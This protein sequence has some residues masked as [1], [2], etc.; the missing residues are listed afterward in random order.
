VFSAWAGSDRDYR[1]NEGTSM[2]APHLAG[3]CAL[4][5]TR[6]PA[7]S[8]QQIIQRLLSTVDVLPSL[9]GL[10]RAGGRLNLAAALAGSAPPPPPAVLP[11]PSNLTATAISANEVRLNWTDHATTETGYEIERSTDNVQFIGSGST[12][13]DATT[14]HV[15]GL[16]ASTSYYFRVRAMQGSTASGYSNSATATTPA[17]PPPPPSSGWTGA[18]VGAVA[19]A[20][21]GTGSG[22]SFTVSGSGADIWDR[23]DEFHY[24]FQA[25]TGD[26][27][28]IAQVTGM[29]NTDGWAKAGI[30]LRE[31]TGASDRHV[32][33]AVNPSGLPALFWRS[34]SG[35]LTDFRSLHYAVPRV[36]LKLTRTANSFQAW[37]SPDGVNWAALGAP[38]TLDL[39]ATLLAGFAVTS[40]RDGTLCTANFE[41]VSFPGGSAPPPATVN[42]PAS[43][44]ASTASG[45]QINLAWTDNATN[46]TG[47][48]LERSTD[49]AAFTLVA[50]PG[51]NATSHNDTGLAAG[52][53][54]YYRIRAMAGSTAS[55]YSNTASAATT[56]APPP[57]PAGTW[58]QA[59]VGA[60][61][62]PGSADA[63]GITYTVRG[64]GS[65][66]WDRADAF[67]FLYQ[68]LSGDC[69]VEARV[70]SMT[71][72]NSW[73]K[74]GVMIRESLA[75]GSRNA[76][77]FLT[78]TNGICSQLRST[79]GGTTTS[80]A[81][82]WGLGMPY[83]IRLV[84]AGNVI[85]AS[86]SADGSTWHPITSY[87]V[88]FG[89][90]VLVGFAVTSHDNSKLNTA[91]FE[92]PFL[93]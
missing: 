24:H 11:A 3:A 16:A 77:V 44:T 32:F 55:A 82:P 2:A 61:A 35:G 6:F 63:S 36:W 92:D 48:Q 1:Y 52:T 22:T 59:D 19:V 10:T 79:T 69:V 81:G 88:S 57:P 41:N 74:A 21:S 30:M 37:Q 9:V 86:R 71:N 15:S 68:T 87:T 34:T 67:H 91:V 72:T 31:G 76:F 75:P 80:T 23:S 65:D 54:Y 50:S 53:T 5:W 14:A 46:E 49:N 45:S 39:P 43:L 18:E 13:A 83:W 85:T 90:Q 66:V 73:A 60:V 42:A 51:V 12:G 93:Q 4:L 47:F 17:A 29:T 27:T 25:W 70:T 62:I 8:P 28:F 89:A 84:R 40:H 33:V 58:S 20:G 26:G 56:A 7:D 64:S 78:P 38:L